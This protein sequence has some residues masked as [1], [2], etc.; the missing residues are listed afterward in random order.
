MATVAAVVVE[1][2]DEAEVELVEEVVEVVVVDEHCGVG[3]HSLV[4]ELAS[5]ESFGELH[6]VG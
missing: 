6:P 3:T 1:Q 5:Q 2:V 4:A